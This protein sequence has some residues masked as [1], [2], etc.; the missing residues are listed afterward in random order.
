MSITDTDLAS[1][2]LPMGLV[3]VGFAFAVSSVT[4]TVVNTVPQRPAGMA[5]ATTS[6]VRDFGFALGFR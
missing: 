6:M 2:I 1:L 5:A 4:G 3:G